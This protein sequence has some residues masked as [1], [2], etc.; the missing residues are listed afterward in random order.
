MKYYLK[1]TTFTITAKKISA[2][3]GRNLGAAN[4][5]TFVQ[6][7]TICAK[8]YLKKRTLELRETVSGMLGVHQ[9]VLAG[10]LRSIRTKIEQTNRGAASVMSVVF[11]SMHIAENSPLAELSCFQLYA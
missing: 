3:A 4:L 9:N 7:Q 10:S 2:L 11:K 6:F 8:M 1:A 5:Q